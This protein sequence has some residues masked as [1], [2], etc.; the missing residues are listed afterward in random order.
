MIFKIYSI[1][2]Q[3]YFSP[4]CCKVRAYLNYNRIPYDIVEVNSVLH[5]ET[6]W[7]LYDRVPILVIENE[8]IQL[9]DSSM[10]VSAIESYLRQPTKTFKNIMKLYKSIV[11]KD[12]KGNISFNYPEKYLIVEPSVND[13]IETIKKY[14][15][16]LVNNESQSFFGKLFSRSK[17]Q[18][19]IES[20]P[21][22]KKRSNEEN[23]FERQ[24]REWIDNKFIHVISP[25]VY[26][27]LRQS[28]YT[29]RWFSKAGDWEEIFPWYE[30]WF[31]VYAGAIVMRLVS[32]RLKKK[33]NLNDDVRV[34][35]YEC[36]D[37]WTNAVGDKDFLGKELSKR[38][39]RIL[40]SVL[41]GSEP[42]L[43]DLNAYGI[44][45]AIQGCEAFDDLM[46]NTKIQPWFERMKQLVETHRVD[47][48]VHSIS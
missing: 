31:I 30:R 10:I 4:F 33:Y 15:K 14:Q 48:R 19:E 32:I 12:Q 36:G 22:V 26:C 44:L 6:K 29:F 17:P 37:E 5:T 45:T 24:W 13:Q 8:R 3:L 20:K 9:N 39:L 2:I 18:P 43:A 42:N 40:Y 46:K 35:L 23:E 1:L 41:G 7:S 11:E 25:N 47:T 28:L 21:I 27:T 16:I 38:M 34:S